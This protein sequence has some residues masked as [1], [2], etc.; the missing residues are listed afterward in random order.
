MRL[1]LVRPEPG[2]ACGARDLVL[3]GVK[4]SR[5]GRRGRGVEG[6]EVFMTGRG[7]EVKGQGGRGRLWECGGGVG[8]V[9]AAA[10]E[11]SRVRQRLGV[12]RSCRTGAA[13]CCGF[14][15]LWCEEKRA[16]ALY[17]G[18]LLSGIFS[19]CGSHGRPH[20]A[21]FRPGDREE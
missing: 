15:R 11:T 3:S 16:V 7:E 20:A 21:R 10:A 12:R 4:A 2:V 5:K 9:R 18:I 1:P 17:V 6:E 19:L 14:L 8:W 13:A